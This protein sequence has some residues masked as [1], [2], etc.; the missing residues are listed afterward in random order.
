[1][2]VG[3]GR[4]VL[5]SIVYTCR[6]A[7]TT[8]RRKQIVYGLGYLVATIL[9]V[10]GISAALGPEGPP[11]QASASPTPQF[12]PIQV[13][14]V[15][16]I[17]HAPVPPT[18]SRTVD[19][20]VRLR[21]PNLRAG[22]PDY[23][24][25]IVLRGPEN[26]TLD[27]LTAS[28]YLLPGAVSYVVQI[29]APVAES[30]SR[31]E[32][33]LPPNPTFVAIPANVSL[34]SFSWSLRERTVRTI[35]NTAMVQQKGVVT[36]TSG[37]DWQSVEVVGVAVNRDRRVIGVGRTSAGELKVGEQRE[38]TLQWPATSEEIQDVLVLVTTNIY[39]QENVVR[40]IGD[41]SLLR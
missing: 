1:M 14:E 16:T 40:A 37:L 31:V 2:Q 10:W 32:V 35:G 6:M 4:H 8:R 28:T 21:N 22:V 12:L 33:E 11:P 41:P 5:G 25:T 38:F 26:Q 19:V 23:P 13:E 27:K 18:L 24:L 29:G 34:P 7:I 36:N 30:I 15:S 39:K 17:E 3:K 20:V 9:V